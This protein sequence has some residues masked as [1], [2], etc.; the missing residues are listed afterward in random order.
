M[1]TSQLICGVS[2]YILLARINARITALLRKGSVSLRE[3]ENGKI[4]TKSHRK[5]IDLPQISYDAPETRRELCRISGINTKS[6]IAKE[7]SYF[8]NQY[9][10]CLLQ[11]N[12]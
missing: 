10:Y 3:T 12:Y 2:F 1:L 9:Q 11:H 7:E 4:K 6:Q 8:Q 5:P